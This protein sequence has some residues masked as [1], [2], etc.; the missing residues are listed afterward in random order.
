MISEPPSAEDPNL[1]A[2][3]LGGLLRCWERKMACSSS[4][5]RALSEVL[6]LTKSGLGL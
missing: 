3:R 6:N 5:K 4:F 1:D 2:V